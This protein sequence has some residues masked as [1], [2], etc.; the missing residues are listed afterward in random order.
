MTST[1]VRLGRHP[2]ELAAR[3]GYGARGVVY[4]LIGGF[5]VLAAVE[6]RRRPAGAREALESFVEWPLGP[7]WLGAV[8]AGLGGFVL[9][10]LLQ[11]FL[12]ADRR[13]RRPA[14]LLFRAGQAFSA[15]LYGVL[16]WTALEVLDGVDDIREGEAGADPAALLLAAPL[17]GTLLLA[18]AAVTAG[19][20]IGNLLKAVSSR[21][22]RELVCT[23]ALRRLLVPVGRAGYAA[24]AGVFA[25]VA[26]VLTEIGLDLAVADQGT[27]GATLS[28][29]E[30]L[31]GGSALLLVT[32][33]ALIAFGLWGLI[34][35]RFRR[36]RVPEA[37]ELAG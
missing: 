14:D 8:A 20:A 36:I 6:L 21:F 2:L 22:G 28:K 15:L 5:A 1:H 33:S 10:R 32:G 31:P 37:L 17:G 19:S 12:D 27:L 16:A 34:E 35:A 4:L 25:G 9:W 30:K 13:G 18:A 7:V 23:T 24:R 26:V 29:L 3:A 11:A